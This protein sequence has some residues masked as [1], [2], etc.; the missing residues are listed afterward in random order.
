MVNLLK[1]DAPELKG[2]EQSKA[3]KIKKTFEPMA[4]MLTSFEKSYNDLINEAEKE[5]TEQITVKAK[6]LRLDIGKVRIEK[7][8][9]GQIIYQL[10][11]LF[12]GRDL[13][14]FLQVNAEAITNF[15]NQ[16]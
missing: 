11:Q 4:E 13:K 2:L 1:I 3:E 14:K 15:I 8:P 9:N 6:R 10:P 5:I 16:K 12:Y 7:Y